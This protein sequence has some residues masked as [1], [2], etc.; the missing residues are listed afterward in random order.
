MTN[1]FQ[2]FITLV[3]RILSAKKQDPSSDTSPLEKQID[4][5]IRAGAEALPL[6][7]LTPQEIEIVY[8]S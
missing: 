2:P 5:M 6:Q 1:D 4:E 7:C 3:N 8:D